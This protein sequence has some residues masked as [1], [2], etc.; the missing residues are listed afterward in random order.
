MIGYRYRCRTCVHPKTK[1]QTITYRSWDSRILAVLPPHLAAEFPARLSHRSG[2]SNTLFSWVRSCFAKGMGG[3][4]VSDAIQEQHLLRYDYTRLQYF[5]V[6]CSRTLDGWVGKKYNDFP[7]FNDNSPNGPRNFLPCAQWLWDM[8]S[9]FME[10]HRNSINQHTAMRSATIIAIDH[11]HKV[12]KQLGRISGSQTHT[13]ILTATNENSEIR[14]CNLV[15]TKAHSQYE[16]ALIRVRH[17]LNLYGLPQPLLAYTD[18]MSDK[19]FLEKS[20]PSLQTGVIP[21]EKYGD[22]EEYCLPPNVEIA[23]K[24]EPSSINAAMET[25]LDDVPSDDPD[26][27]IIVGFDSE[28]NI[29]VS[30]G[31]R[32]HERGHT[33]II[34]IAYKNRVYILQVSFF[35]L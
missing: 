15:V 4:Q 9:Q 2:I 1:K 28:W 23:V 17:S 30:V 10:A 5:N 29:E 13:A 34:Q 33:S 11:S 20:F 21:V 25:I 18:N 6:L 16:L 3:K 22:L 14:C 35:L 8:Y 7:P 31:G 32:V 27:Q 24:S 26:A 19:G 12:T